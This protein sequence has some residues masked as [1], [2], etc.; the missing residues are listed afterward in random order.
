MNM[1]IQLYIGVS[2]EIFKSV[3]V[4]YIELFILDV[5]IKKVHFQY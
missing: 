4:A 5:L 2:I 3:C 1:V